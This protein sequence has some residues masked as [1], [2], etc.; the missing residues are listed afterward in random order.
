MEENRQITVSV[1]SSAN[2]NLVPFQVIFI[3]LKEN[4]HYPVNTG[5]LFYGS[6]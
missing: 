2:D 4:V 3:G 1:F 5:L 6:V